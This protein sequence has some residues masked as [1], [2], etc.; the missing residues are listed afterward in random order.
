MRVVIADDVMI[1]RAGLKQLLSTTQIEVVGEATD[2]RELLRLVDRQRPDVAIV[3]IRMPP[4]RHDEGIVAAQAIRA[5]HPDTAVLV[6]SE[7]LQPRYA[8]RLLA[9]NPAGLGYLLKERVAD[10]TTLVD[11]LERVHDGGCVVDPAIVERL[12]ALRQASPLRD[13]TP[14]ERQTLTL[15][16]QGRSNAGI[17]VGLGIGERS[18]ET[19]CAQLFRKL[20]LQPDPNVNRRVLA[21]LALLRPTYRRSGPPG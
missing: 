12:M 4:T 7:Y 19:L 8:E 18:V 2:A 15:I 13:L 14:R 3:D 16:A 9:E 6:L 21:V 11:A 1:V 17:A 5:S 20:A 10:R